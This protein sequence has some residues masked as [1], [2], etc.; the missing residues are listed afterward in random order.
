[1]RHFFSGFQHICKENGYGARC[2]A[3]GARKSEE[4]SVV[5]ECAQTPR[6]E[7]GECALTGDW[8]GMVTES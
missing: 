4:E 6:V 2:Y 7:I 3:G 1:M 5:L 8:A